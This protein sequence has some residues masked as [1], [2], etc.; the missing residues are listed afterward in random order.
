MF[1]RL[2]SATRAA[3]ARRPEAAVD[4]RSMSSPYGNSG[5]WPRRPV[6]P[7]QQAPGQARRQVA[8]HPAPPALRPRRDSRHRAR[9][10]PRPLVPDQR[11]RIGPDG[12][13][14]HLHR[15]R[16]QLLSAA[17][18]LRRVRRRQ[19]GDGKTALTPSPSPTAWTGPPSSSLELKLR[20]TIVSS[21]ISPKSVVSSGTG[22]VFAQNMMYKHTIT[23]YDTKTLKLVKTIKDAVDPAKF[24]IKGHGSDPILGS[25]VEAG[26]PARRALRVRL[27]V[28]DVRARVHRGARRRLARHGLRQLRVPGLRRRPRRS[29]RS[30]RSA[31]SPSTSPSRPTPSTCS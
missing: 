21:D 18:R 15:R 10:H 8:Y 29:T 19:D 14:R 24:H 25:P 13:H 16:R 26:V 22:Y 5:R 28:L 27:A 7:A 12:D 6:A 2:E 31:R 30:S 11:L 20:K 3:S 1:D 23:V 4:C 17:D 9:A